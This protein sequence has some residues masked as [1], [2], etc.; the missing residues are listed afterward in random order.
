MMEEDGIQAGEYALH[1]QLPPQLAP[2]QHKMYSQHFNP[3]ASIKLFL[4]F[5]VLLLRVFVLFLESRFYHTQ[6][7]KAGPRFPG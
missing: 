3:K 5:G 4:C 1:S 6:S 7:T 2:V